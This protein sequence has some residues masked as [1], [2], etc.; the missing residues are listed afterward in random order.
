MKKRITPLFAAGLVSVALGAAGCSSSP[1]KISA[2]YVSPIQY[3]PY[4]CDQIGMELIRVNRKV[5]EVSGVQKKAADRD[6]LAMGVG[7]LLFWP[8]LFILAGSDHSDELARLK[9]E[10]EALETGPSRRSVTLPASY[11]LPASSASVPWSCRKRNR[12]RSRKGCWTDR[13]SMCCI[14]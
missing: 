8:A 2:A 1:E 7:L 5:V 9:G 4:D 13:L 6:A 3:S 14:G 12:R 11:R 10:Y